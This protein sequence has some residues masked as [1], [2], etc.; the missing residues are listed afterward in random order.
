MSVEN[1]FYF[2]KLIF[3]VSCIVFLYISPAFS[4]LKSTTVFNHKSDFCSTN[5]ILDSLGNFYRE[6]G[7]EGR[8]YI[9]YG[10]YLLRNGIVEFRFYNFDS[11]NVYKE[12]KKTSHTENDSLILIQFLTNRGTPVPN[13]NFI[14]TAPDTSG[15][16]S[17]TFKVDE[18]GRVL[19][20]F[21]KYKEI[22]LTYLERILSKKITLP[23]IKSNTTVVLNLPAMFFHYGRPRLEMSNVFSL[24]L[25]KD[26][27][28]ELNG[29]EKVYDLVQ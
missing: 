21:K 23:L 18:N 8:S 9:A 16:I 22:R 1:I 26:G 2:M 3:Y 24:R 5:Y 25:K 17:Q 12:I 27:L 7:C 6:S 28:Y 19:L 13:N 10:K 4:Q 29:K 11:I 20:N 15:K 14:I